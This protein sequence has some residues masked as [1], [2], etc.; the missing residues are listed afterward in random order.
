MLEAGEGGAAGA[1]AG[2]LEL[3]E[4]QQLRGEV[5]GLRAE[6]GDRVAARGVLA[7]DDEGVGHAA[8]GRSSRAA[9]SRP[10]ASRRRSWRAWL[11]RR[12]CRCGRRP[13]ARRTTEPASGRAMPCGFAGLVAYGKLLPSWTVSTASGSLRSR[14]DSQTWCPRSTPYFSWAASRDSALSAP[15][16]RRRAPKRAPTTEAR[17]TRSVSLNGWMLPALVIESMWP[18]RTY[19]PGK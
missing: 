11:V 3:L 2:A 6:D 17:A 18:V 5:A 14:K 1:D 12:R 9:P 8:P 4:H 13:A 7:G 19:S 15:R 16:R 10:C